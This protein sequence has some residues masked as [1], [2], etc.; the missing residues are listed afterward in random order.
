MPSIS[1]RTIALMIVSALVLITIL[2]VLAAF[3]GRKAS[4]LAAQAKVTAAQGK[5]AEIATD[6][7]DAQNT[8]SDAIS[9]LDRQNAQDIN[10]AANSKESAGAAG[11][12]GYRAWCERE[13]LRGNVLN[14]RCSV[15]QR[16]H[17]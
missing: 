3:N 16:V 1:I 7:T 9:Q 12:A 11:D 10:N 15:M 14:Q 4:N 17:P 2:A 6:A 13:R 5:A 8:R